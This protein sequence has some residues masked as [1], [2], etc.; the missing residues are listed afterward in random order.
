MGHFISTNT[1]ATAEAIAHLFFD[2]IVTIHGILAT[3]IFDR[4]PKFTI[5]HDFIT[6]MHQLWEKTHRCVTTMQNSQKQYADRQQRDHSVA[7]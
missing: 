1:T 2:R 7:L 6:T 4:D 5:A 3:L